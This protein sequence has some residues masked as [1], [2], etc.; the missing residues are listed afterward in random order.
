MALIKVSCSTI[1]FYIL[2]KNISHICTQGRQCVYILH[3]F[4]AL[5]A[6]LQGTK[7]LA[8]SL[9]PRLAAWEP[10]FWYFVYTCQK[11]RKKIFKLIPFK[12]CGQLKTWPSITMEVETD[13]SAVLHRKTSKKFSW[14]LGGHE[15]YWTCIS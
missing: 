9:K 2:L 8:L 12:L 10:S 7:L 3:Y 14:K 6:L 11:L 1:L 4:R 15:R 13:E 5:T